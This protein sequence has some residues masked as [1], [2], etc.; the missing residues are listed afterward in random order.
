MGKPKRRFVAKA[1]SGKGWRI[2]DNKMQKWWGERYE[3]FPEKL[4][5]ELNGD[6]TP[7]RIKQLIRHTKRKRS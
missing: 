3:D 6:K 1:E 2:W 7:D 5:V 4:L